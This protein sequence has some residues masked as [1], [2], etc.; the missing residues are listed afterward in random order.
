MNLAMIISVAL[1]FPCNKIEPISQ[2]TTA[3]CTGI[4]WTK[5][6]SQKALICRKVTVPELKAE[7]RLKEQLMVEEKQACKT[8]IEGLQTQSVPPV[9]EKKTSWYSSK[10]L[11]VPVSFALGI[12]TGV[13]LGG[14]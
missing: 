1:F 8:I 10:V 3:P 12:A 6:A 9:I 2:G 13:Y 4:L 14:L 7:L 11:W 5:D